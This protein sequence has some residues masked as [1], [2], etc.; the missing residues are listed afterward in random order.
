MELAWAVLLSV[1]ALGAVGEGAARLFL[2]MRDG[3][4]IPLAERHATLLQ[5]GMKVEGMLPTATSYYETCFPHPW[6]GFVHH[7]NPP[8]N[9]AN[10]NNVGLFG[11]DYPAV[12]DE[13]FFTILIAGGSVAAQF[14]Q[15][16]ER[17]PLFLEDYLN[18]TYESPNGA[19]FRTLNGGDG[20]WKQPQQAILLLLHA[21]ALDAVITLDGFNEFHGLG[22][23]HGLAFPAENYEAVSPLASHGRDAVLGRALATRLKKLAVEGAILRRS[24]LAYLACAGLAERVMRRWVARPRGA[25]RT[26]TRSL[27]S[28]PDGWPNAMRRAYQI[29][30]YRQFL[31]AIEAVARRFDLRTAYF[32]QPIPALDKPLAP[33]EAAHAVPEMAKPYA[34]MRDA[35]LALGGEG[36]PVH[37][38]TGIF[39][40][41]PEPLYGD[42]IH[43]RFDA[44]G[45]SPGYRIMA[46]EIGDRLAAAWGLRR[47]DGSAA[48]AAPATDAPTDSLETAARSDNPLDADLRKLA[49][50]DRHIADLEQAVANLKA[51]LADRD[52]TIARLQAR[53]TERLRQ[54]LARQGL[55]PKAEDGQEGP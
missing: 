45:E 14:G 29:T 21:P 2:R 12:R 32:I 53:E 8:A 27:F 36:L 23:D 54:D 34:E 25:W 24:A 30:Q 37:S 9:L 19:P 48:A 40:D 47:K 52:D 22:K 35:L 13:R 1:L 6:L 10:I 17:G 26:T 15:I 5:G 49:F 31:L 51:L 3:R 20:A 50:H 28:L 16:V 55:L 4:G 39:K 7:A 11:R 42:W 33:E 38:L 43:L 18:R 44:Q 46:K 41:H